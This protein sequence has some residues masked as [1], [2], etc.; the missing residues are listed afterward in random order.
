VIL[1]AKN[2]YYPSVL[3]IFLIGLYLQ[4]PLMYKFCSFISLLFFS[5]AAFGMEQRVTLNSFDKSFTKNEIAAHNIS[6]RIKIN[7]K[8]DNK[9][10][11]RTVTQTFNTPKS[12]GITKPQKMVDR[13]QEQDVDRFIYDVYTQRRGE[14]KMLNIHCDDCGDLLIKYQKDGPGRLLRCYLDR[15]HAPQVFKNRQHDRFDVRTAPN[16]SCQNQNCRLIIGR[17]MIYA[18]ETR[19]AY[20]MDNRNFYTK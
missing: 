16:L 1:N 14:P 15:I 8:S 13:K 7:N 3:K 6:Y 20:R 17:P 11:R 4:G 18:N 2:V 5:H 12:K 10:E 19:P 9:Q